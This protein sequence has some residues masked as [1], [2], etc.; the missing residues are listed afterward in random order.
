ML[1]AAL[2]NNGDGGRVF[3]VTSD[4]ELG[5]HNQVDSSYGVY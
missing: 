5:G 1:V 2:D 4:G 3:T